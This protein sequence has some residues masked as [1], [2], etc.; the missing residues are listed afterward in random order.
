M[1]QG[2]SPHK[3]MSWLTAR[4]RMT[5]SAMASVLHACAAAQAA[6]QAEYG[7]TTR[8]TIGSACAGGGGRR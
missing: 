2:M 3:A 6:A 5:N 7:M 8:T 4:C 1:A